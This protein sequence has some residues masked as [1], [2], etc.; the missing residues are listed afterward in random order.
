MIA[1]NVAPI[2]HVTIV[3]GDEVARAVVAKRRPELHP[4][5]FDAA[6]DKSRNY[7]RYRFRLCEEGQT[8]ARGWDTEDAR[9]LEAT[10]LL[11]ASAE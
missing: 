7:S 11:Q 10:V 1:S 6:T 4:P 5:Q 2:D 8:W 9:A 3:I